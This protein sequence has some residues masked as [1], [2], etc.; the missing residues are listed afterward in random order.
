MKRGLIKNG[1]AGQK[2]FGGL[3]GNFESPGVVLIVTPSIGHNK[4]RIHDGFHERENPLRDETLE[5]PPL[6]APAWR[7]N[8][9]LPP[10]DRAASSCS[11]MRRPTGTPVWRDCS[12]SQARSS[13]V[14][15]IVSV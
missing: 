13:S 11:R 6:I 1:L 5:E 10:V 12:L 14:R 2:G 8:L 15:R 3:L 4:A 7:R 9:C